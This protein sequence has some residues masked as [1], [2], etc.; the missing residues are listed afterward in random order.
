M[1]QKLLFICTE[2][3]LRSPTACELFDGSGGYEA[4]GAGITEYAEPEINE[5]AIQWADKIICLE[6]IHKEHLQKNFNE[7]TKNKEI[8]TLHI[9]LQTDHHK[10]HLQKEILAKLKKYGIEP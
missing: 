5:E 9:T 4:K 8:I 2:N 1:K 10:H 6:E 3:E 7:E